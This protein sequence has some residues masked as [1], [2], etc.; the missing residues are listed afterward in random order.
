MNK[1]INI[2][3]IHPRTNVKDSNLKKNP[4]ENF[5]IKNMF[6]AKNV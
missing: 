4:T 1:L 2:Y 6:K 5:F 3:K